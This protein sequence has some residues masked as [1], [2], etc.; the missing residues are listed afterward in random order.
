MDLA[1]GRVEQDPDCPHLFFDKFREDTLSDGS[2]IYPLLEVTDSALVGPYNPDPYYLNEAYVLARNP[3]VKLYALIEDCDGHDVVTG[4][5]VG[6][7]NLP[8][9]KPVFNWVSR[10]VTAAAIEEAVKAEYFG[11]RVSVCKCS[12]S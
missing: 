2:V 7:P 3:R 10:S 12:G 1:A 5:Y 6:V 8:G 9:E 11:V 4:A